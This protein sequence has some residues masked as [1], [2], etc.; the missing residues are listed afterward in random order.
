MVN[1]E[2][3][4]IL[5]IPFPNV[6]S[7]S[8]T[9]P[10]V[11]CATYGI[12]ENTN[13]GYI[14]LAEEDPEVTADNEFFS[15]I[16]SLKNA[17]ALIID[18][19][20]NYGGWALFDNAFDIL[21]NEFHKTV[22]D[23]YRCNTSTFNLCPNSDWNL[24]QINGAPPTY[25]DRPIAVLLGPTCVSCGD[26]TAQRLRYHPMVRFFGES[27]DA[28]LGDNLFIENFPGWYL[29]NS[30]SDMFHSNNV[31]DYLNRRE[32][33]IDFPVWFNQDDVALG[34]DAV[35][36]KALEWINTLTYAHNVAVDR[37]YFPPGQGNVNITASLTNPLHHSAVLSAIVTDSAGTLRDSVLLY[38]DGMHGDGNAGDSLWGCKINVPSDEN[39]FNISIRTNDITDTTFRR[40]PNVASFTTEGPVVLD[41]I[42]YL[43][44]V[45]PGRHLIKPFVHN[46]GT[47]KTIIKPSVRV[48]CND[49]WISSINSYF[50]ILPNITPNS[51]VATS[52]WIN[53]IVID[54]L[55]PGYFNLRVEVAVDGWTYWVDST[56]YI[57]TGIE[58]SEQLPSA[59][60]LSQNYP[61]PFNPTTTINYSVPISS[62]VT[63]KVYDVL[64]REIE[65]LVNE[66]KTAGNYSVLFNAGKLSSGVYFYQLKAGDYTSVKKMILLK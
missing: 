1:N 49:P 47:V 31:V 22:E 50:F 2:Q 4:P 14:Y 61:N 38:D 63:I 8:Q 42:S 13:I 25:Y 3:L 23:A 17:D 35:V 6:L 40:L 44:G 51:S 20:L 56:R 58:D 12:M 41:S 33:P 32:F 28:S 15:A 29:R 46:L 37:Y 55:F 53:I 16:N 43:Q 27:S 34:K 57:I 65:T 39:M 54:S 59:F 9:A 48:I 24:F 66:E 5:N 62:F 10:E 45:V 36:E 64:G 52:N 30:I 7:D 18:M 21:F 60:N 11:Q 26:V 19:R